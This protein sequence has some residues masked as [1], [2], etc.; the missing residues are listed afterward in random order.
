MGH[1]D[2]IREDLPI[3]WLDL[4]TSRLDR[5]YSSIRQIPALDL[6]VSCAISLALASTVALEPAYHD[7]AI[8]MYVGD[9]WRRGLVPYLQVFDNKPPGIFFVTGIASAFPH[10]FWVLSF[11]V[12]LFAMACILSVR[13]TLQI[14]GAPARTVFWGT[15]ATALIVNLRY[16]SAGSNITEAYMLAPMAASICAFVYALHSGKLRY[17][18]L[19]GVCSGIACAFKPFALSIFMAQVVFVI[20]HQAPSSAFSSK[21]RTILSAILA[22]IAG[23]AAAWAPIFAYFA[24]HG[25]LK[26][27]LDASFF[28][29][30]HYGM[31]AQPKPLELVDNFA[32]TLLPLSST[33]ACIFIGLVTLRKLPSQTPTKRSALWDLTLLWFAFG[34]V[35][36][37][38]AGRGY[39]HYFLSLTPALSMAAVLVFWSLEEYEFAANL[40]LTLYTLLL[41]PIL[42][43]QLPVLSELIHDY[44]AAA[45][46]QHNVIPVE[47]AATELKRIAPPSS[48]VFVWGFE[49]WILSDTHLRSAFR[50][51]TAQ[52]IYDSPRAYDAVGHEILSGMQTTP[53]DYVVITPW[54]FTKTWPHLSDPVQDEFKAIVQQSYT[55]VWEKDSFSLYKRN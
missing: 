26:Q 8:F 3:S 19:A 33:L 48:T 51:P 40:R 49:P 42:I 50:F 6:L 39:R 34:L 23:A 53:P 41:S 7:S 4:P 52:Y 37:F 14:A 54:V 25:A 1:I 29:N 9:M 27:M 22:N 18:F 31:A 2:S 20:S 45:L 12:F 38:M 15:I 32:E 30:L 44:I 13:K 35:L 47:I 36:V 24:M 16:Y 28:Y 17:I 10:P 46:R 55:K 21:V 43:T 5:I 11:I